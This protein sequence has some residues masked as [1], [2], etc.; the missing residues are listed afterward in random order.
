MGKLSLKLHE[1]D[2]REIVR[3]L[4]KLTEVS[5]QRVVLV[6]LD[7]L[8]YI[9]KNM[10]EDNPS[11]YSETENILGILLKG[12]ANYNPHISREAFALIGNKIFGD[13]NIDLYRR[14]HYFNI[15]YKKMTVL[16]EDRSEEELTFFNSGAALNNIY[17]FISEYLFQEGNMQLRENRKIAFFPGTYDLCSSVMLHSSPRVVR[18]AS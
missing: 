11:A 3:E 15:I 8:I 6:A 10:D 13:T 17:R 1:E 18:T 12:I 2:F 16:I 7:T 9:L 14:Y 4:K 5:N